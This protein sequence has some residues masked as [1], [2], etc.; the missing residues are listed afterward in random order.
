MSNG[1]RHP[2]HQGQMLANMRALE[3]LNQENVKE[4]S[5]VKHVQKAMNW[6]IQ[7]GDKVLAFVPVITGSRAEKLTD[8]WQGPYEILGKVT[9]VTYLVNM[10]ERRK[11]IALCMWKQ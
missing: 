8:R 11:N 2:R 10:P 5:K 3:A 6:D 9:P 4:Y 7:I 1:F